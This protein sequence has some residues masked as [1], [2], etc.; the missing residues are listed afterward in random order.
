MHSKSFASEISI[1]CIICSPRR[2]DDGLAPIYGTQK[3]NH[4]GTWIQKWH[5][6]TFPVWPLFGHW[7]VM[8]MMF[9]S[10]VLRLYLTIG[11]LV[12]ALTTALDVTHLLPFSQLHCL[13]FFPF[14]TTLIKS[15]SEQNDFLLVSF[16]YLPFTLICWFASI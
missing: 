7:F 5:K 15:K 14:S 4:I 1:A 12:N 6:L 16:N 2:C 11:R 13:N 10:M 9:E 8:R 3:C